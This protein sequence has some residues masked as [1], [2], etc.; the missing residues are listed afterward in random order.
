[1]ERNTPGRKSVS[2]LSLHQ[3]GSFREPSL[4]LHHR[5][6][7]IS[8]TCDHSLVVNPL[9]ATSQLGAVYHHE[10]FIQVQIINIEFSALDPHSFRLRLRPSVSLPFTWREEPR[11]GGF[12]LRCLTLS[13]SDGVNG[14]GYGVRILDVPE[15]FE[16]SVPA[17]PFFS[18]PEFLRTHHVTGMGSA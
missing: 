16:C 18:Y 1:M 9:S 15:C 4:V 12:S 2:S 14:F 17:P 10:R 7:H 11:I 13:A 3:S 5:L 8:W 6:I